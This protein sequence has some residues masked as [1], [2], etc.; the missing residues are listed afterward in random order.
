MCDKQNE[1]DVEKTRIFD[2]SINKL[3][4]SD[5]KVVEDEIDNIIANPDIGIQKKGDLSH[6]WVHKFK[7]NNQEVLLGYSWIEDSLKLYLLSFG[8]HENFYKNAKKRRKA[9]LKIVK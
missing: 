6:L 7:I 9:D 4:D 8:S 5:R 2:K 3:S 1:I